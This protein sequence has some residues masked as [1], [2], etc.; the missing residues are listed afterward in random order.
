M[1]EDVRIKLARERLAEIKPPPPQM[2][3]AGHLQGA[4]EAYDMLAGRLRLAQT[5][6][7]RAMAVLASTTDLANSW[8]R[9]IGVMEAN[10]EY[11]LKEVVDRIWSRASSRF[12]QERQAGFADGFAEGSGIVPDLH[13]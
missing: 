7:D 4:I 12:L 5:A 11:E 1:S 3:P 13:V 10:N 8:A 6:I 2:V 9:E